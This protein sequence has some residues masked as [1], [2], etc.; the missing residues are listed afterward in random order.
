MF[1]H[2][3]FIFIIHFFTNLRWQLTNITSSVTAIERSITKELLYN[4]DTKMTS[5]IIKQTTKKALKKTS[6]YSL[7]FNE[8]K[9]PKNLHQQTNKINLS[10]NE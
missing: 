3:H 7:S 10:Q 1:L 5:F 9:Y 8:T 4:P 2:P 6:I